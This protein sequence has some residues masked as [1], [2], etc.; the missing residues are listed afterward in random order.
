[1]LEMLSHTVLR[2]IVEDVKDANQFA[3]VI[4]GTQDCSGLE[5]ESICLRYVSLNHFKI[6]LDKMKVNIFTVLSLL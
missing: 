2:R 3:V 1:M 5:Q 4:D 6:G